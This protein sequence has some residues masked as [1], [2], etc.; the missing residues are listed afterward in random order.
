MKLRKKFQVLVTASLFRK[1]MFFFLVFFFFNFTFKFVVSIQIK[2]SELKERL[3]QIESLNYFYENS[4]TK[5]LQYIMDLV[6]FYT[7][8]TLERKIM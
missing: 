7:F 6:V 8:H 3:L 1:F 5:L 2:S 4:V